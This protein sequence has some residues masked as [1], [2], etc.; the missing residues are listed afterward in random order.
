MWQYLRELLITQINLYQLKI[1]FIL[2]VD[3][4]LSEIFNI[5]LLVSNELWLQKMNGQK[6]EF[7]SIGKKQIL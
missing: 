7:L 2:K 3:K 6:E 5:S 4:N 1:A